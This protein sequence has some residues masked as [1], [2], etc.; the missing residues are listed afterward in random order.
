MFPLYV[1]YPDGLP[2]TL[3]PFSHSRTQPDEAG[4][5]KRAFWRADIHNGTSQ[6]RRDTAIPTHKLLSTS[7]LV[8]LCKY[9]SIQK[10]T[11]LGPTHVPGSPREGAF[12]IWRNN[13]DHTHQGLRVGNCTFRDRGGA[14]GTFSFWKSRKVL[15][16]ELGSFREW[17]EWVG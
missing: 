15:T 12:E 4:S 11:Q 1:V 2:E 16:L 7:S 6:L 9:K 14:Q 10:Y 13:D 8:A 5:R 17:E 3:V